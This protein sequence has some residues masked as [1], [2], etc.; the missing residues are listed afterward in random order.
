[1]ASG[2]ACVP[3][4]GAPSSP[5]AVV[6]A[7]TSS[8]PETLPAAFGMLPSRHR[9]RRGPDFTR[10]VRTGRRAGRR[11]VALH[12]QVEPGSSAEPLVGF[13]VPKAVGN[14]VARNRSKRRLR[15]LV[16]ARLDRVPAGALLVVRA[17]SAAATATGAELGEDLDGALQRLLP[18]TR[19]VA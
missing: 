16:A 13:V 7:A 10:A 15:A 9:M 12:L 18:Q 17:N 6:R 8:R 11:T 19:G 1:M 14:A 4:Q 5:R 2:C 3:E